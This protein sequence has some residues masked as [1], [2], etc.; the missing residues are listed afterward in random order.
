MSLI[1]DALR[2]YQDA[3]NDI[4]NIEENLYLRYENYL[5]AGNITL[6]G[7]R[8]DFKFTNKP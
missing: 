6:N 3:V 7:S 8:Y 5:N 2:D 4:P 1:R